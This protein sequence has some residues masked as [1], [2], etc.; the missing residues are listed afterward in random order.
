MLTFQ[1]LIDLIIFRLSSLTGFEMIDLVLVLVS[2]YLL[3]RLIQRS[4]AALLLRGVLVLIAVLFLIT[5]LLPLPA[6]DWLVRGA[7]IAVLVTTPIIFQPELRRVLERIGGNIGLGWQVRQTT[8]EQVVPRVVRAVESMADRRIGA[9]VVFEGGTS[10]QHIVETGVSINGIVTSELL[11][12]IF[13]PSNPLHD[14]ATVLRGNHVVAA[15]CVLPLTQRH[16]HAQRRLGTRHRAAV[17][18]SEQSDSLVIVVSEETGQI[19]VANRGDLLRPLDAANL[20]RFLFDFFTPVYSVS[21]PGFSVWRILRRLWRR[22]RQHH[23]SWPTLRLLLSEVGILLV[24]AVLALATWTIIIQ[25]TNPAENVRLENIP[26]VIADQP[27]NT[28]LMS[29]LPTTVSAIIQTTAQVRPTLGIRS[30]QAEVSLANVEPGRDSIPINVKTDAP[31]VRIVSIDPPNLDI[32]LAAVISRTVSVEPVL[33][34]Q[35]RVSRAY[36]VIGEGTVLPEQVTVTGPDIL[37]NRVSHV[38]ATLSL[39][40]ASASLQETRPFEAVNEAGQVISGVTVEPATGQM[41]VTVRRRFNARDVGVRVLTTGSPPEGYWLSSISVQPSN[42]TLQAN[43]DE[44]DVLG[45]YIDTLPVDVSNVTGKVSLQA[46][47]D[48]PPNVQALNSDGVAANTV[49]VELTMSVREGNLSLTRPIKLVGGNS[50][51]AV[52]VEPQVADLILSGPLPTLNQIETDPDLIQVLVGVA[53]LNA[54][55]S[56]SV[57][58]TIKAPDGV[59]AQV[60]PSSVTVTLPPNGP[61]PTPSPSPTKEIPSSR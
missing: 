48:L 41:S 23:F 12:A 29:E 46:P 6:F 19:S 45:S 43:P 4:R 33:I 49:T 22:V 1:S 31:Q 13:Y 30:F 3:L 2:F 16:L 44:L 37:V 47:L 61:Q 35:Q 59:R 40:N 21:R 55:Q 27:A 5:L 60:I 39:A 17:G 10:L 25:E 20:R 56:N 28:T 26:L 11:Q 9:L 15:G 36:Q 51:P 53:G 34:D 42:L 8:V 58:P 54:G 57:V 24:S 52:I 32:R 38:R 7:L 50:T 18:M 14:G